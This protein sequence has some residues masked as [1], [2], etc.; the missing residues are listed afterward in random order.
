MIFDNQSISVDDIPVLN[1]KEFVPLEFKYRTYLI[2][3]NS[4]MFFIF[5]GII[6]VANIFGEIPESLMLFSI[7]YS[8][9]AILWIISIFMV[10]VG[11]PFKGY[12]LRK[13]DVLYK[14]GFILRKT[15]A[16]PKNRIQHMEIRQGIMLRMFSLSK[17]VVFTAGGNAS[18]LSISG[19]NIETAELLK[20]EIGNNIASY[21]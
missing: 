2:I 16:V 14:T 9:V 18:D 6:I 10:I 19:I 8:V 7:A 4:I 5:M 11:F 12:L 13:H 15:I 21:E 20:E 17:L 3:R 1:D